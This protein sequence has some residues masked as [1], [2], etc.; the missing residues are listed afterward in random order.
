[1]T[2]TIVVKWHS[3]EVKK[4][5]VPAMK[6]PLLS[7]ATIADVVFAAVAVVAEL[8]TFPAVAMVANL[9]STMAAVALISALTIS[10]SRIFALVM[11]P[12]AMVGKAAVPDRS[13]A[14]CTLPLVLA[15]ASGAPDVTLAST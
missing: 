6:L 10:P 7:R 8:L 1:M 11:A 4:I 12:V 2:G 13:P 3:L 5:K 9:V 14:N 15:L